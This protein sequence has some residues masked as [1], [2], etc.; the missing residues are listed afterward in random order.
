VVLEVLEILR[1]PS[2]VNKD[3]T[4]LIFF[5]EM[6]VERS[7]YLNAFLTIVQLF[8]L[9]LLIVVEHSSNLDLFE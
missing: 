3:A 5:I 2:T 4:N 6:S 7:D 9:N 8:H 1:D